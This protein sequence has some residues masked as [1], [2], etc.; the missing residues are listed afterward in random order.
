MRRLF[1]LLALMA[2]SVSAAAQIRIATPN[3]EM[4]LNAEPGSPFEIL[5]FGN[6]LSDGDLAN[7]RAA[8]VPG[9][10]AY[11]VYGFNCAKE[12]A[13]ALTHADGNM[14]TVMTVESVVQN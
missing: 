7:L 12:P 10:Y 4:V 14:S 6:R 5:Y 8:G 13:L 11:P 1:F 9:H 2:L 3:I